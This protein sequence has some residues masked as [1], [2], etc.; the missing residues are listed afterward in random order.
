MRAPFW[1]LRNNFWRWWYDG[2]RWSR[3][4]IIAAGLVSG[5]IL[6]LGFPDYWGLLTG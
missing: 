2:P 5:A 1:H 4:T 6:A 3:W